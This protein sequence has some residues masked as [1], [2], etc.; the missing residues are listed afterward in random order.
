MKLCKDCK[1][2]EPWQHATKNAPHDEFGMCLAVDPSP[3]DGKATVRCREARERGW[4]KDCGV[5]GKLWE[6]K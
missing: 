3:V 1:H 5:S 6:P 2:F 4:F